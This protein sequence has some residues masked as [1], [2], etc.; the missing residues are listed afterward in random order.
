MLKNRLVTEIQNR[1]GQDRNE[2]DR[3]QGKA[4][5]KKLIHIGKAFT[6]TKESNAN[7]ITFQNHFKIGFIMI[8][9]K[10]SKIT[11]SKHHYKQ[12]PVIDVVVLKFTYTIVQTKDP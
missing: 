10:Q 7:Y 1:T 6:A 2:R 11:I 12:I 5:K 8:V 4:L 3:V 9:C